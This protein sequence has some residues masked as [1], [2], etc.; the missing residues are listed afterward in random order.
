[1]E[2]KTVRLSPADIE[3][4][5]LTEERLVNVWPAV[6][7]M[8][9]EGWVVRFANGY[10]SR[11]NSASANIV[12]AKM[13]EGLIANIEQLYEEAGLI[14]TV[15]ITPLVSLEV[16]TMLLRRGY[17]I[18]DE[19]FAMTAKL[20]RPKIQ[21]AE[22]QITIEPRPSQTWLEGVSIHQE[23]SKHSPDHLLAIVGQL[24]V[25][26]A[27]AMA[28]VGEENAG[29]GMGA[30]DRGWAEIGS[31]IVDT[32]HR[33]K[34]LGRATVGALLKWAFEQKAH[35]A[36]LQVSAENAVARGLYRSLGFEDLCGYRT[37][38]KA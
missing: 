28:K 23:K 27:F 25:P 16:E 32:N 21:F 29:F 38:V 36:F 34:G 22:S 20:E 18:K 37:L 12:G 35:H 26:S 3:T 10:S 4:V 17:R 14:P 31:I 11:A 30:I 7:T 19:A 13:S 15:R 24:R 2:R 5:R 1:M 33:S 6:S 8:L 9:M